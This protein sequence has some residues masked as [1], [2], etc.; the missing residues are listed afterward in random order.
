M[1]SGV[2]PLL[3]PN[4]VISHFGSTVPR[5]GWTTRGLETTAPFRPIGR[6]GRED[7]SRAFEKFREEG[8]ARLRP[9]SLELCRAGYPGH[10]Y[11]A[12][13]ASVA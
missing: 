1:Y 5:R 7:R 2:G 6:A 3:R 8:A 11:D 9:V 12:G 13:C 10:G 4:G